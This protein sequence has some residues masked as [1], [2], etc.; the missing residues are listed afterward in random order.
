MTRKGLAAA[1]ALGARLPKF[2]DAA[3]ARRALLGLRDERLA[4][5]KKLDTTG[6]GF[7]MDGSPESLVPLERWY[8]ALV[9][10]RGFGALG[11]ERPRFETAMG[12]YYGSVAVRHTRARWIVEEFAFAPGTWE[13]GIEQKHFKLM[14]VDGLCEDWHRR[15]NNKTHRA[16]ARDYAQHFAPVPRQPSRPKPTAAELEAEVLKVL[17]LKSRP[18]L[19]PFRLA[20]ALR[21]RLRLAAAKL[22][23]HDV[24]AVLARLEKRKQ[25]VRVEHGGRGHYSVS[26]QLR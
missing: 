12:L 23:T 9:A 21:H 17:G 1:R 16:L 8:F 15:P 20:A 26:Y 25:V 22:T 4:E 10:R 19:Y 18:S 11:M 6:S 5:F 24:M 7:V 14:G 3:A 2:R 13:L